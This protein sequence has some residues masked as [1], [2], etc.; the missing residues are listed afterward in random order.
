MTDSKRVKLVTGVSAGKH[1]TGVKGGKTKKT[2]GKSRES[3]CCFCD[4]SDNP[5]LCSEEGLTLK[6]ASGAQAVFDQSFHIQVLFLST[7][8]SCTTYF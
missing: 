6:T 7:L 3:V 1:A 4:V 2:A 5:L 8:Q